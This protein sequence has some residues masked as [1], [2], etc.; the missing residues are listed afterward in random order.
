[1]RTEQNIAGLILADS[2]ANTDGDTKGDLT[3]NELGIVVV[4]D[5][6]GTLSPGDLFTNNTND[7]VADDEDAFQ[8]L[9]NRADGSIELSDVIRRGDI[10]S[11]KLES[12]SAPT[13]QIDYI[14]Y[15]GE[16][17]TGSL[18]VID[19][20][21]YY[22][23]LT[24]LGS[25]QHDFAMQN[26]LPMIYRS[27]ESGNTQYSIS[28][29]IVKVFTSNMTYYRDG[30]RPVKTD[31][32]TPTTNDVA[33][34]EGVDTLTFK[35]GSKGFTATDI[36]DATTNAALA[37]GDAIRLGTASDTPIYKIVSIDTANDI[38]V[39]DRPVTEDSTGLDTAYKRIPAADLATQECG[40]KIV[41]QTP[42]AIPGYVN[43]EP[44][45]FNTG[46]FDMGTT[47]LSK[48]AVS[49]SR[50]IGSYQYIRQL[51]AELRGNEGIE[52]RAMPTLGA[53]RDSRVAE[54][55]TNASGF[56]V[57]AIGY[58]KKTP[59]SLG[60]LAYSKNQLY[61]A[62]DMTAGDETNIKAA[63]GGEV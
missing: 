37:V 16:N 2:L 34:G 22:A 61:V 24:F 29:G 45:Y 25:T 63:L 30:Y 49:P 46:V 32:V 19:D 33:L 38:G 10:T 8:F 52:Y 28:A 36:D 7:K 54:S 48:T 20:N 47:S 39:L 55:D 3:D 40:V 44:V 26:K 31:V 5:V 18:E 27:E 1:M 23:S 59:S 11:L 12:Y 57:L 9:V 15:D 62:V 42:D 41:G 17:D 14:G 13:E 53:P 35:E 4:K 50:G 51:E 60:D 21:S 58:T 6:S 43:F 56:D